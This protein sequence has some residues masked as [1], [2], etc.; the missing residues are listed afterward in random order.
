METSLSPITSKFLWHFKGNKTITTI[1][2]GDVRSYINPSTEEWDLIKTR[3]QQGYGVYFNVN[4]TSLKGRTKEHME[5]IRCIFC[6][7]DTPTPMPKH[8]WPIAPSL[9]IKTSNHEAGNKYHYY[10]LTTTPNV[11]QWEDVMSALVKDYKMDIGVKDITRILRL[12]GFTNSKTSPP[13]NVDIISSPG[14]VYKWEEI[15][16]AF[17]PIDS[18]ERLAIEGRD[19]T[20]EFN[21]NTHKQRFLCPEGD[22]FVTNSLNSLIAHWCHHYSDKAVRIQVDQLYDEIDTD[23]LRDNSVR[24]MEARKQVNKFIKSARESVRKFRMASAER[25]VNVEPLFAE[26]PDSLEWDWSVLANTELPEDCLPEYLDVAATEVG[27]WN[28]IGKEP[29]ALSAI[30]MTSAL[31]TKN[32][33]IHETYDSL[34]HACRQGLIIVMDTGASKSSIYEH[35]NKPFFE[36]E[37]K[38]RADWEANKNVNE[39]LAK[40]YKALL[41]K[42]AADFMKKA[43]PTEGE[44]L[45]HAKLQGSIQGR[46]DKLPL[47]EPSLYS[48]DLTEEAVFRK[49]HQNDGSLALVSDDARKAINILLGDY[50]QSQTGESIYINGLS[51]TTIIRDRMSQDNEMRIRYPALNA[52][53]FVQPDKALELKNSE[54]YVPSGLAARMPMYFYPT[55]GVDI[56]RK[57]QRRAIDANKMQAYYE[58]MRA[59]CVRRF[60]NPLHVRLDDAA[61]IR[62]KELD[63][64]FATLLESKWQNAHNIT[65]KMV[66]SALQYATCFAAL[67][68]QGFKDVYGDITTPDGEYW[69]SVRYINMG[70]MFAK[71]LFAQ[72]IATNRSLSDEGIPRMAQT[73]VTRLENLYAQDKIFEG[74]VI[75]GDFRNSLSVGVRNDL[76]FI[77]DFL[78]EKKWVYTTKHVG[79]RRKLN[80]GFP[81]KIVDTNDLIYHL[82]V[83]GIEKRKG[84]NLEHIESGMQGN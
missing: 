71:S 37:D 18:K 39:Q 82:N 4:E 55:S 51:G 24:Y 67:D 22:G 63:N 50:K 46:I 41:T 5:K 3:N 30:F 66:S 84:M 33:L 27:E 13:S 9:I 28:G 12:P 32:V 1:R 31:L 8:D 42:N 83:K 62:M 79:E 58:H 76:P 38:L 7:Q 43:D 49:M 40:T 70:F 48:T 10:W 26:M 60:D 44:M 59:I 77:M 20:G 19:M 72:S 68:D 57:R 23:Q 36:Y 53:F 52:L 6:D 21:V 81:N 15:V 73:V 45:E 35:M 61:M 54:M 69:L 78:L 64:E 56:V 17:P 75:Q 74:F 14:T 29:A 11:A 47:I 2:D 65:N 80:Y 25:P 34:T 16:L